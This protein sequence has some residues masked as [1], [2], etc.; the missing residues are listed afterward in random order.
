MSA[1]SSSLVIAAIICGAFIP[2]HAGMNASLSRTAAHPIWATILSFGVSFGCLMI[3]T[4]FLRPSLPT[5]S[6]LAATTGLGLARRGRRGRLCHCHHVADATPG[7]SRVHRCRRCRTDDDV[8]GSRPFRVAWVS[9]PLHRGE[10][11]CRNDHGD[12]RRPGDAAEPKRIGHGRP[13]R[14]VVRSA[15][16]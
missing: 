1:H 10:P 9:A 16:P 3:A 2:V 12:W 7:N 8:S 11:H 15:A 4:A 14:P 13:E 6:S 5:W